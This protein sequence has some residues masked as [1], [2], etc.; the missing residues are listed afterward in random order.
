MTE[1]ALATGWTEVRARVPAGWGELVAGA[2]AGGPCT[3]VTVEALSDA[4]ELVRTAIARVDD[5]PEHR[6]ALARAVAALAEST[7]DPELGALELEFDEIPDEDWAG[8]WRATWRPFRVGRLCVVTPD[9]EGRMREGDR[10]LA[11]TPGGTFGT[12]RH[13]TTRMCMQLVQE[14]VTEGSR[15]LDVGTG[16]GILAVTAALFGARSALGFDVDPASRP[17]AVELARENG[18][19][20]R[21]EFRHG[22]FEVLGSDE[23]PFEAV[24]ANLYSDL[25]QE[26]ARSLTAR[27]APGGLFVVSGCPIHHLEPTRAAV[28]DA[29]IAVREVRRRGRWVTLVGSR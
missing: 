7:G 24:F 6:E 14:E 15:V 21:C 13:A 8:A 1:R 5:S 10:Q 12:G 11:L 19:A 27:L 28:V 3:S 2:L 22:G 16:T 26:H 23:G 17:A 29:G 25:I 20:E 4:E 9:W 18:V